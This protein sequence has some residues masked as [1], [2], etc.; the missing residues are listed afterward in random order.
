M[1]IRKI[2][3]CRSRF[4]VTRVENNSV[5]FKWGQI[6]YHILEL[7]YFVHVHASQIQHPIEILEV[8]RDFRRTIFK[9]RGTDFLRLKKTIK[10]HGQFNSTFDLELL[11]RFMTLSNFT[12]QYNR[13]FECAKF[14]FLN[15]GVYLLSSGEYYTKNINNFWRLTQF[16]AN[17]TTALTLYNRIITTRR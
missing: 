7:K 17:L 9:V 14:E 12:V 1:R 8:E 13:F 15:G 5:S 2:R 10:S 11:V 16:M 6:E 3:S 4:S